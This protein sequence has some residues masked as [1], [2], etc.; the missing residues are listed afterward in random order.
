MSNCTKVAL[1]NDLDFE[2]DF[3]GMG[4]YTNNLQKDNATLINY[5]VNNQNKTQNALLFTAGDRIHCSCL[6]FLQL[7]PFKED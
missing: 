5:I 2:T 4:N 1:Q 7:M 6:P 3:L